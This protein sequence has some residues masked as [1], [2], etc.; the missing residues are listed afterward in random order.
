MHNHIIL[1]ANTGSK[2][3]AKVNN[4]GSAERHPHFPMIR[5]GRMFLEKIGGRV[6]LHVI[7]VLDS[8]VI[9]I[10]CLY[11]WWLFYGMSDFMLK[12]HQELQFILV[13]PF[14]DKPYVVL[15]TKFH[16]FPQVFTSRR[17]LNVRRG[18]KFGTSID[19]FQVDSKPSKVIT[20]LL[21]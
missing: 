3:L 8:R 1:S 21:R 15:G 17:N 10:G 16:V 6:S 11:T 20:Q 9:P 19:C 13:V 18:T 2:F 7:Q 4:A 5:L 12:T 14:V